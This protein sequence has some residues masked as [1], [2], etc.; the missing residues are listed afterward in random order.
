MTD[1][2]IINN[3][4]KEFGLTFTKLSIEQDIKVWNRYENDEDYFKKIPD[5][6]PNKRDSII[7]YPVSYYS[8]KIN[9]NETVST[10]II[11]KSKL[12]KIPE[13]IFSLK[14]LKFLVLSYNEIEEVPMEISNLSKLQYLN[15][16]NNNIKK[17]PNI[18]FNP[19]KFLSKNIHY[20]FD[21]S[22]NNIAQIPAT[23]GD[24]ILVISETTKEFVLIMNESSINLIGNNLKRP[25][26]KPLIEDNYALYEYFEIQKDYKTENKYF[27]KNNIKLPYCI[28]SLRVDN[29]QELNKVEIK[30]IPI[31]TKWIFVTGENGYGK[32]SLLQ[33]IVIGFLGNEDDKSII[34][35]T[36]EIILE[37]RNKDENIVNKITP[38]KDFADDFEH[39]VAYGPAR[40]IKSPVPFTNS[41]T[42]SLFSSYSE[43]LDIEDKLEKWEKDKEQNKYFTSA[44]KILLKLL[45]E[46]ISDI[47]IERDKAKINV[48]YKEKN[49]KNYKF[50]EQ[51][52]SGYRSIIV[53][54]GDIMIRL[55]EN[56]PEIMNFNELS[57]IVIIDEI[58]LHL[59][60]KW[61]KALV[62][63][64]TE[65]FPKIQ[66]IAS[67]HSP[68]PI[69]GAPEN[70]VIINV[71]RNK[72]GINAQKLDIDFTRLLPNSLLSSPIF[73]FEEFLPV[74]KPKN[75][76][77]HT[78][79]DYDEITEK[80]K[81]QK[82]I[83][84]FLSEEKT[85]K[86]LNLINSKENEKNK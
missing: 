38:R 36:S 16:S 62:E 22:N 32:T 55:L 34:N 6:E 53:M 15:L 63:K 50:F 86:L 57:G 33:S 74:S 18:L 72:E 59:H 64:L 2:E 29:Y 27:D 82:D 30:N 83:A 31:D 11:S 68:I 8:Y 21:F 77:P 14:D 25:P 80:V 44:K 7:K 26:I 4:E 46:H 1:I 85:E 41:K 66:F 75:K 43:L 79:D 17:L 39:F 10:I 70:S 5:D 47:K 23:S 84:E 73:D 24:Y 58:D 13:L 65:L 20:H 12:K 49:S 71:Q 52:A 19:K 9:E 51:L 78:E 42:T 81:L 40:L 35:K 69:L 45:H 60:P 56:Q 67:T 48:K 3:I 61:Q 76:F 54:I 37:Y 28:K